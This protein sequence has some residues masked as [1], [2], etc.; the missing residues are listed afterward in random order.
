[1]GRSNS[2]LGD[3]ARWWTL[4]TAG[5]PPGSD[6]GPSDA[7]ILQRWLE[8]AGI[9]SPSDTT[10]NA[11]EDLNRLNIEFPLDSRD[12][13]LLSSFYA[14]GFDDAGRLIVEYTNDGPW[15]TTYLKD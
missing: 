4:R 3:A 8:E 2:S 1:M 9:L 5:T 10:T 6:T 12:I 14:G 13:R 11:E 7:E 15:T